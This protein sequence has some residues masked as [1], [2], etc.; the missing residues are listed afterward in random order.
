MGSIA[1]G[2][3]AGFGDGF[4]I[5]RQ[6][7]KDWEEDELKAIQ[8]EHFNKVDNEDAVLAAKDADGNAYYEKIG[9][10]QYRLK[11]AATEGEATGL[12]D[13]FKLTSERD[14]ANSY[15]QAAQA[16]GLM[17]PMDAMK[18]RREMKQDDLTDMQLSKAK[19]M[20]EVTKRYHAMLS[21]PQQL[22][23]KAV[24]LYNSDYGPYGQGEHKGRKVEA[25]DRGDGT[26]AVT[27]MSDGTKSAVVSLP[28][29]RRFVTEAML[30]EVGMLDPTVA[31]K[32]AE[33]VDTRKYREGAL[34]HSSDELR[35]KEREGDKNRST[36]LEV[37]RTYAAG[38]PNADLQRRKLQLEIG[39]AEELERVRGQL[40]DLYGTM[41]EINSGAAKVANPQT[42]KDLQAL[43]KQ[44]EARYL[45]LAGKPLREAVKAKEPVTLK[46]L[47][48][49]VQ[50]GIIAHNMK[51]AGGRSIGD[52]IGMGNEA[53]AAKN[54]ERLAKA[55]PEYAHLIRGT[56]G[57]HPELTGDPLGYKPRESRPAGKA[58]GAKATTT[59]SGRPNPYLNSGPFTPAAGT[60]QE[61][62]ILENLSSEF[63]PKRTLR[64]MLDIPED[65]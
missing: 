59:P 16:R 36:Q 32:N 19:R 34:K 37:A 22:M 65:A 57:F 10:N 15:L 29:V 4:T 5:G 53:E 21:D 47:P 51:Y 61:R 2:L 1:R 28:D 48:K 49:D 30:D 24:E 41:D 40:T 56:E 58:A 17:Q 18:L 9:G 46:E 63:S 6:M 43:I 7:K 31:A 50:E 8:S 26:W 54:A 33:R 14:A 62:S 38:G 20:D 11:G 35:S 39:Q 45:M 52:I 13:S 60:R 27:D 3:A 23:N 12:R 44:G 25:F 64:R 42:L 55:F